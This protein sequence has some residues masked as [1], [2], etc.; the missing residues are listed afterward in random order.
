MQEMKNIEEGSN[1]GKL[2]AQ[3]DNKTVIPT[4]RVMQELK[5]AKYTHTVQWP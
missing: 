1:Q 2:V 4:P 3:A 5:H